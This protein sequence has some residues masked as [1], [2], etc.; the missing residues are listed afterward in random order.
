[1]LKIAGY[2]LS[3][4]TLLVR[5]G[6]VRHAGNFHCTTPRRLDIITHIQV[7]IHV[8]T[9]SRVCPL[10]RLL[11][12]IHYANYVDSLCLRSFHEDRR[13]AIEQCKNS[14]ASSLWLTQTSIYLLFVWLSLSKAAWECANVSR[15]LLRMTG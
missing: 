8:H 1:M 5:F 7:Y 11:I 15:S 12:R 3:N 14:L 6:Y 13:G 2:P 4:P 10:K 9:R